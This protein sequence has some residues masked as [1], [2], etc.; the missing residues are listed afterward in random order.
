M[1][2]PSRGE[3]P[4]RFFV[5]DKDPNYVYRFM[6]QADRRMI[7]VQSLGWESVQGESPVPL[8]A[9]TL[10]SGQTSETPG[11]NVVRR[12]DLVLMRMPKEQ[13][14]T[15]VKAEKDVARERQ[16]ATIDTMVADANEGAVRALRNLG[17]RNVPRRLVFREDATA[18][19][20]ELQRKE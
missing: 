14:E 18:E 12:G 7:E 20:S 6:N 17:Y 1:T 15:Q 10:P 11:G 8:P 2:A 4:D 16:D 9:G 19:I 3:K 5:S 13:W